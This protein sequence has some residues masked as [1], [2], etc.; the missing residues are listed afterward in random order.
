[1][2]SFYF[3]ESIL[4]PAYRGYGLGHRF[5]D[6]RE[7]HARSFGTF[8]HTCFCA[9]QRPESHPAK[10]AG[11]RPL[12]EFWL[13]RGYKPVPGLQSTF[14]WPDVGESVATEKPMQYWSRL[15]LPVK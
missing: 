12:D 1:M 5:F 4:L 9:V 10:P 13:K 8:T 14:S 15:L 3:G 11:Y 6:Q 2:L 7:A